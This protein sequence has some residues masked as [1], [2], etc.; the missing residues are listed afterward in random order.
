M[1]LLVFDEKLHP[2]VRITEQKEKYDYSGYKEPHTLNL[3]M[4]NEEH[5]C[6]KDAKISD[7]I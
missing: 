7:R 5:A 2:C 6:K 3:V 1:T 4:I